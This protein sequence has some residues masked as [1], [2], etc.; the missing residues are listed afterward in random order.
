MV[1]V[2]K[3]VLVEVDP[4]MRQLLLHLDEKLALGTRFVLQDLDETPWTRWT[5]SRSRSTT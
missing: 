4:A 1:N 3:G 5:S 2:L